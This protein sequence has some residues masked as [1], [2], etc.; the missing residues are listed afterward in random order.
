MRTPLSASA[1]ASVRSSGCTQAGAEAGAGSAAG[2]ASAAWAC[3]VPVAMCHSADVAQARSRSG[4]RGR[5]G[6]KRR[7]VV[8]GSWGMRTVSERARRSTLAPARA[9]GAVGQCPLRP[10]GRRGAGHALY[11]QSVFQSR[12][13][14]H[15]PPTHP[16]HPPA[17]D[18]AVRGLALP[19]YG[20]DRPARRRHAAPGAG[21]GRARGAPPDR[22]RHRLP[23]AGAAAQRARPERPRP[24]GDALRGAIALGGPHRLARAV[25]ARRRGSPSAAVSRAAA[26][27][28]SSGARSRRP[29]RPVGR[30]GGPG[31]RLPAA[32]RGGAGVAHG[33]ARPVLDPPYQR[34]RLPA[35]HGARG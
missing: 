29:G 6:R 10:A 14:G 13:A 17:A 16:S 11:L 27:A 23:G 33:P 31:R 35:A 18:L 9:R 32:A 5:Y 15:R 26:A 8:A 7:C 19:R 25:A 2:G 28:V 24:A 1:R 3:A 4:R 30:G 20:R 21:A 22:R 12:H 34:A